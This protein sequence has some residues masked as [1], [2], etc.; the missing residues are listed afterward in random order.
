MEIY[1]HKGDK[2]NLTSHS[3]S[4]GNIKPSS[5]VT[6]PFHFLQLKDKFLKFHHQRILYNIVAGGQDGDGEE[7]KYTNI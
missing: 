2:N 5:P 3:S 1:S 6:C 7:L 4:L